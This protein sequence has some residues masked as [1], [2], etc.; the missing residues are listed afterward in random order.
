M[1]I[2]DRRSPRGAFTLI[3]LLVVI[4]VISLLAAIL[5]PAFGR[6]REIARRASCASNLKQIG[7]GILQYTQD[8]DEAFPMIYAGGYPGK[9]RWMDA[10]Q[11]YLKSDQ[12]FNC[13]SDSDTSHKYIPVPTTNTTTPSATGAPTGFG[14]YCAG[15]AYWG[16]ATFNS[17]EWGSPM[18]GS[19]GAANSTLRVYS[20]STTFLIGEGNGGFQ[21]AWQWNN[22][23][24]NSVDT[25]SDFYSIH[26]SMVGNNT[27]EGAVVA[28]HLGTTNILY[29]DGHVKAVPLDSLLQQSTIRPTNDAAS[30]SPKPGLTAFTRFGD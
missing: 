21:V 29:A 17:P 4:A 23:Q 6:A 11:A 5:F 14:S 16:N 8:Y 25:S 20:P 15:N 18:S 22:A 26:N 1:K 28:R 9:Y 12:L 24:P 27:W 30:A 7:L 2:L 19:G 3:E 13:P 10:T